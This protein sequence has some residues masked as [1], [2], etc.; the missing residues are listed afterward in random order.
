MRT[1]I[2]VGLAA[3]IVAGGCG[4]LGN[5][6]TQRVNS[7]RNGAYLFENALNPSN[8]H[9]GSFGRLYERAV[10]GQQLAN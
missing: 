10:D 9:T 7:Y 6:T 2:V 5:V 3:A 8:V 1:P 4:P